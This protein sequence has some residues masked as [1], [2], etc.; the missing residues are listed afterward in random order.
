M[1]HSKLKSKTVPQFL[2]DNIIC[3]HGVPEELIL[4]GGAN[5]SSA[6]IKEVCEVCGRCCYLPITP[7]F[8]RAQRNR[9]S[10]CSIVGMLKYLLS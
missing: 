8:M 3:Y 7:R 1:P 2:V 6:I 5:L 10:S 4:D 9:H